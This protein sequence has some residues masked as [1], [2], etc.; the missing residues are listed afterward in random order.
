MAQS[1][2]MTRTVIKVAWAE[3]KYFIANRRSKQGYPEM[4]YPKKLI[5]KNS[6]FKNNSR[7][8]LKKK[9]FSSTSPVRKKKKIQT[10]SRNI[11]NSRIIGHSETLFMEL[12]AFP[13]LSL[14]PSS[15]YWRGVHTMFLNEISCLVQMVLKSCQALHLGLKTSA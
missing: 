5:A 15:W 4:L 8:S 12:H 3:L 6:E 1:S 14:N 13:Q 7:T 11:R 10:N 9:I 2:L